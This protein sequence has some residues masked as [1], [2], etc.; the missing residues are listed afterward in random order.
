MATTTRREAILEER[1]DLIADNDSPLHREI[2]GLIDHI[3]VRGRH[4]IRR[5]VYTLAPNSATATW[6]EPRP[7]G[8]VTIHIPGFEGT[9]DA[10]NGL[11]T[12]RTA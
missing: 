9:L 6:T 4:D 11:T 8:N 2:R 3:P 5:P 1:V 10:L 12:R 7:A